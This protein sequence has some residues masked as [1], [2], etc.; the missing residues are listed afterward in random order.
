MQI[1]ERNDDD[2]KKKIIH[3]KSGCI[4]KKSKH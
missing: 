4:K 2:K 3:R 1:N